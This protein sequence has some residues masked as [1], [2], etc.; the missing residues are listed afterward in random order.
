MIKFEKN[1]KALS[2]MVALAL[3]GAIAGCGGGSSGGGGAA[4]GASAPLTVAPGA[5]T[6]RSGL[7]VGP[8]P[9]VLGVAGNYAI[10]AES[11]ISKTGTAGTA[12]TG[13]I[14]VSP[15]AATF[16]QGFS[17]ILDS[18]ECFSKSSPSTLVTGEVFAADYGTLG[19]T[20]PAVLTTATTNMTT[21]YTDAAGRAPDYT[22]LGAGEIGGMNL[23][24]AVYKWGTGVLISNDVMLTGGPNDVWIFEIADNLTMANGKHVTLA[25][26]ALPKNIFWQVGGGVGVAIGTTAHFEGVVLAVKAITL[27]TGA[28]A[29]GRFLSQTAV[30]LDSNAITQPAP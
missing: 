21:A 29:N 26:G 16:I 12:I 2:W 13:D 15:A 4:S 11:M 17:L 22:E 9:V 20:T 24:P 18:T 23:P 8:S 5:G 30:T 19:C 3:G 10:L 6:G 1:S 28:S 14:A 7:G 25:G 27:A